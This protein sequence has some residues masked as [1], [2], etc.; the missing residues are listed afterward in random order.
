M[1]TANKTNIALRHNSIKVLL[2]ED[3][4]D[5][6]EFIREVLLETYTESSLN[7]TNVDCLQSSIKVLGAAKFDLV[8]LDLTLPDSQ[9]LETITQVKNYG[10]K[11]PIVVLLESN[12]QKLALSTINAGAEFYLVKNSID[13]QVLLY[14]LNYAVERQ[15]T[16]NEVH[17]LLDATT[18]ISQS[19][20]LNEA[21]A[22][23]LD[24]LC[25]HIHWNF[26]EAWIVSD[27]RKLNYSP[28]WYSGD[29]RLEEF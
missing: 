8:L 13:S 27:D 10:A 21:L 19:Q 4:L 18:A 25:K 22:V 16:E 20:D 14:C 11:T 28:G 5:D 15:R 2:I 6:V 9:G 7:L 26:G 3:N 23:T 24:L 1:K 12:D 17:L 29:R